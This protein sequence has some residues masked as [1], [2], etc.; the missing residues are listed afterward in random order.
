MR[1]AGST[2]LSEG[3]NIGIGLF[4]GSTVNN[5]C[6]EV[7]KVREVKIK[8]VQILKCLKIIKFEKTMKFL[9]FILKYNKFHF[10]NRKIL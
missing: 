4:E 1:V 8:I 6:Q 7:G 3:G 5:I 2:G 10:L 9:I